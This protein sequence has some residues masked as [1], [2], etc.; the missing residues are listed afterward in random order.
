MQSAYQAFTVP[1]VLRLTGLTRR[2]LDYWV[3]HEVVTVDTERQLGNCRVRL[4]SFPNLIE[5]K[6]AA[7]LRDKTSLQLIRKIVERL[8]SEDLVRPLAEVKVAVIESGRS[9]RL[10]VVVQRADGGWERGA[11][12][13]QI[14]RV[15][16]PLHRFAEELNRSA[17][18]ER[19]RTL[20][21][22]QVERRRG[23]LGSTPV[24]A[25]TRVP[26]ETI[27]RLT[28]AGWSTDRILENYPGLGRADIA[29]GLSEAERAG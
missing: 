17:E 3:K 20:T 28:D 18:K 8:R 24:I 2:Q 10:V 27:R 6:T 21:A 26:T 25:G 9:G 23:R 12:G 16:V 7:W 11:D 15:T 1:Q 14:M 22:G 29:A 19:R 5:A 4:F 13:Q